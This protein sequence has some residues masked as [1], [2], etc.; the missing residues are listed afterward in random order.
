MASEALVEEDH[1]VE[2]ADLVAD[3]EVLVEAEL[4]ISPQWRTVEAHFV[5]C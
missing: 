2:V 4:G 1:L 3:D 5:R